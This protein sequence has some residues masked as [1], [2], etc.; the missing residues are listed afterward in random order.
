MSLSSTLSSCSSKD[1]VAAVA[2]DNKT[3]SE[4]K[5]KPAEYKLQGKIYHEC[6]GVFFAGNY[7]E[8]G[9]LDD[10][11]TK[12]RAREYAAKHGF[13]FHV[14]RDYYNNNYDFQMALFEEGKIPEKPRRHWKQWGCYKTADE[15][16][17]A[18]RHI[19]PRDRCLYEDIQASDPV[20]LHIDIEA[21]KLM[22]AGTPLPTKTDEMKSFLE[23]LIRKHLAPALA[24]LGVSPDD[25]DDE[26]VT[27]AWNS[28]VDTVNEDKSFLHKTSFHVLTSLAQFDSNATVRLFLEAA[29]IPSLLKDP[30]FADI[31]KGRPCIDMG[32][33]SDGRAF[34]LP[35]NGKA[36]KAPDPVTG[37][38]PVFQ[39]CGRGSHKDMLVVLGTRGEEVDTSELWTP[40]KMTPLIPGIDEAIARIAASSPKKSS[41][42]K[43]RAP[44]APKTPEHAREL[45]E[46]H[47][48][49]LQAAEDI[50]RAK[51]RKHIK[52]V[53]IKG[54]GRDA[55]IVTRNE[56]KGPHNFDKKRPLVPGDLDV[57]D[58]CN[59]DHSSKHLWLPVNL[60][61]ICWHRIPIKAHCQKGSEPQCSGFKGI[62]LGY[63]GPFPK[64]PALAE[65]EAVADKTP[66]E[67]NEERKEEKIPPPAQDL[68]EAFRFHQKECTECPKRVPVFGK[69]P[70]FVTV[71]VPVDAP[72]GFRGSLTTPC[73]HR[74]DEADPMD[75][76]EFAE[77]CTG[78]TF[79]SWNHMTNYVQ[80]NG[81]RVARLI[82]DEKSTELRKRRGSVPMRACRKSCTLVLH[83]MQKVEATDEE[84]AK[85]ERKSI[86]W[87][88]LTSGYAEL[89]K[90]HADII[91]TATPT[92]ALSPE[93]VLET[94]DSFNIWGSFKAK[95]LPAARVSAD[96]KFNEWDLPLRTS[97]GMLLPVHARLCNWDLSLA[98]YVI[99]RWSHI[100][101]TPWIKTE[102]CNI[103]ITE[104]K[105]R[106]GCKT[107]TGDTLINK[108]YGIQVACPSEGLK[109]LTANFNS[110]LSDKCYTAFEEMG[111]GG[112]THEAQNSLKLTM[113]ATTKTCR[114]KHISDSTVHNHLNPDGYTN[115]GGAVHIEEGDDRLNPIETNKT[116]IPHSGPGS[117]KHI[118][119]QSIDLHRF[120]RE[121]MTLLM[122]VPYLN[123][124]DVFPWVASPL[125]Y[126]ADE[127][128]AAPAP[129]CLVHVS[130]KPIPRT[131]LFR[132]LEEASCPPLKTFLGLVYTCLSD[133]A[134]LAGK[135][136]DY[137]HT[138]VGD[139]LY[140][141]RKTGK[142][143]WISIALLHSKYYAP[144]SLSVGLKH[145]L[146]QKWFG[147]DLRKYV[148]EAALHRMNS[149][150]FLDTMAMEQKK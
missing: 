47:R 50:L 93:E 68:E 140:D 9:H 131:K 32:I 81:P 65:A 78:H 40:A 29:V 17:D 102:V 5:A 60:D 36:G 130:P 63:W 89:F 101:R 105:Q 113:S 77:H 31:N 116:A 109:G 107:Y 142:K 21:Y 79:E 125:G 136:E 16:F 53:S 70:E 92:E 12:A 124:A 90:H 122:L 46:W 8:K 121:F 118:G 25:I 24:L 132:V 148:P 69:Y 10:N 87:Q 15:Y 14:V 86:K 18:F 67:G 135:D 38:Y 112:L 80:L 138:F 19:P 44:S 1:F 33:Y 128:P 11:K 84:E 76:F 26:T 20:N 103:Y 22:V 75:W 59:K 98:K 129:T 54:S 2:H 99:S 119:H 39:M 143:S 48:T 62:A 3:K 7:T 83:Y 56:G 49:I 71:R 23:P 91:C 58:C 42:V 37:L 72:L 52:C 150:V 95:P 123:T 137:K 149:G 104:G 120:P 82:R 146:A 61:R 134:S 96:G 139:D 13:K 88:T 106:V 100:A 6:G 64:Q 144:W 73:G 41:Y 27:C 111:E 114:R 28:R 108:I 115:F 51:G 141:I 66:A 126:L 34:S 55:I 97:Y 35:Y 74:F 133:R 85:E 30:Q 110:L 4:K 117:L 57:G 145:P 45:S 147:R 94:R 43:S 127:P